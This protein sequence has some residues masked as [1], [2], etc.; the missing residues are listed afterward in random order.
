MNLGL[1]T[2]NHVVKKTFM[3]VPKPKFPTTRSHRRSTFIISEV[4]TWRKSLDV[5]FYRGGTFAPLSRWIK[6]V[7]LHGNYI[8]KF[9]NDV[10]V[11]C[12][13]FI[14]FALKL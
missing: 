6:C 12:V 14:E 1:I 11:Y 4:E 13:S 7:D 5:N 3:V 2:C 9:T 10:K 8:E